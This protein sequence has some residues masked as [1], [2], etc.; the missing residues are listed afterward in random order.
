M[1]AK[2]SACINFTHHADLQI[3]PFPEATTIIRNL[4]NGRHRGCGTKGTKKNTNPREYLKKGGEALICDVLVIGN[5]VFA[6]VP[7]AHHKDALVA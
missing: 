3:N 2:L 7:D 6:F 4:L 1:L 5:P